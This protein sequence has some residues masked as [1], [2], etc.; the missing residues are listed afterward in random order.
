MV[1]GSL[2]SCLLVSVSCAQLRQ[3]N[4]FL[5]LVCVCLRMRL[6]FRIVPDSPVAAVMLL[7]C[8][9]VYEGRY[10]GRNTSG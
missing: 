4:R 1:D 2:C 10:A 5:C 8:A 7:L 3:V 9:H 6:M